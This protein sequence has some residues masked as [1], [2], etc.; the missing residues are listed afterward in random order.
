MVILG[1][2]PR[3]LSDFVLFDEKKCEKTTF[4]S[5]FY[6]ANSV[7]SPNIGDFSGF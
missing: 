1:F 3:S 7:R 4:L 2:S 6:S 5:I